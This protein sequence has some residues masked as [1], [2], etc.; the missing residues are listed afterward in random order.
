[1]YDYWTLEMVRVWLINSGTGDMLVEVF[2]DAGAIPDEDNLLYAETVSEGD[3]TW[4]DTGDWVVWP[5]YEVEIP[6]TGFDISPGTMYWLSLQLQHEGSARIFWCATDYQTEWWD[7]YAY[8]FDGMWESGHHA[9]DQ[10]FELHGS[11][12]DDVDPEV[13][14]T[15][16]HD[17]DFP[18]GVPVDTIVTFHVTDDVSGCDVEETTISVEQGGDQLLGIVTFDDSDPLD[19]AFTWEPD[20][21]YAEGTGVDVTVETYD[22]AG[23]GPVTEE[24]SF[25]T[26]YTNVAPASV[27]VIKAGFIE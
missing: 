22:L 13:T 20:D 19:V 11:L 8:Y 27:G 5:V 3:Y 21:Y 9:V 4:T 17:E 1:M 6:I 24:W 10:V 15:Y 26:G 14:E 12:P 2:G 16:P 7:F 23:N 18:S 25:T